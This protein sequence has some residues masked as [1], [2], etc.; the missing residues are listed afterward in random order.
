VATGKKPASD[1]ARIL[2]NPKSTKREK[3]VAAS[4]LAQRRGAT[5]RKGKK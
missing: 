1:A 3:E 4:D 5:K 2:R